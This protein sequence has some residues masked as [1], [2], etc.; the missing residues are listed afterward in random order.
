MNTFA[1]KGNICFS[2][3]K[4]TL[5]TMP[6]SILV[7]E[8]GH[9]AGVF[10]ELPDKYKEIP[11]HDYG[12]N[13][14]VPGLVDLHVHAPQYAFRGLG[15]DLELLDWL[16]THTFKEEQKYKDLSYARCAYG[17]FVEDLRKSGTT[18]ACIFGTI[19][20]EATL[21]L[22]DMLE[23][24]GICAYVG[25]VN[26]DRNGPDYLC[27][28]DAV[29][30]SSDTEKWITSCEKYSCVSPILTP[31]FI[32]SCTDDLMTRIAKL[33]KK[34]KLPVQSHLSENPSEIEWVNSL[35][36]DASCYGGAYD[37]FG[38]FGDDVPTIMAHCVHSTEEEIELLHKKQVFVAHCPQSNTNLY[39]GVAPIRTYLEKGI[40]VGLGSDIAAGFSLSIF[41]AM[42]DAIQC[43]KLRWRLFDDSSA[44]LKL[45]EVFYMATKGGGSFFGKV[46]SFE[47]GYEF[48]AVVIDD[49]SLPH[50]QELDLKSRLERFIYLG[51]DRNISSVYTQGR[52][53]V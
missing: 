2:K 10:S 53:I 12:D 37:K 27:E 15:M 26:M 4:D 19:H 42:A 36:P 1:L 9:N 18:R 50:P 20:N 16:N 44:P 13:I 23:E 28:K 48:D 7:C 5:C 35:H 41:R 11:C 49:S 6:D 25:K 30:S 24:S 43:S 47:K 22:M 51:D 32:P 29:V 45:E 40:P 34:Y 38:L 52:Q 31:R 8:D 21:L 46:G 14:I 39:S 17:I 33:Q 3:D